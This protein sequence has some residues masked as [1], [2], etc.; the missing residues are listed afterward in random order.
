MNIHALKL[1]ATKRRFTV[2]R[3]AI[4]SFKLASNGIIVPYLSTMIVAADSES[5]LAKLVRMAVQANKSQS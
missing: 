2:R 5:T 1:I 4:I 3:Y